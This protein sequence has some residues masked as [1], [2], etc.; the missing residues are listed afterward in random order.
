VVESTGDRR[1]QNSRISIRKLLNLN[2]LWFCVNA[3]Y[4][5]LIPVVIPTQILLFVNTGQVGSVDQAAFLSWLTAAASF[6]SLFM[7]PLV[8]H[9]SDL[10]PGR[11]GR[12]RP[13]I[14]IGGLLQTFSV[15]FLATAN[16]MVFFLLGLSILHVGNN[17]LTP[18]YQGLIPDQVSK[19]QRGAASGYVGAMTILGNVV[20]LALA[21]SLLGGITQQA[22]NAGMIRAGSRTYYSIT[23]AIMLIGLVFT[24]IGVR[25]KPYRSDRSKEQEYGFSQRFVQAW[26]QPW[27]NYNFTLVFFTRFSIMLGLAMFMTFIEYYFARVQ[28]IG[29]FVQFTAGV[30]VLA[31]GG[32]VFSGVISGLFSDRLKRR[33]PLVTVATICMSLASFAFVIFPN[34]LVMWLW[35]LG[36]LFGLGYGTYMSVDWAL[37]IDVLP[38]LEDAG[39]DLGLWGA[40]TTVPAIIAPL[41]GSLLI[42]I[43]AGSGQIEIGYR[44]V[45]I[46]AT[47]CLVTAAICI[48]L[49][50]EGRKA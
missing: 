5:A 39:K 24:L 28:H 40:S 44:L 6:I 34:T 30:A 37:S 4:A 17:I 47:L 32:G 2:V 46:A 29:N 48:L 10:T 42:H 43:A 22:Y 3:Q 15:I 13:Y 25:E 9:F 19:E 21:A 26:V 33:A 12:R 7:P 8:G 36:V 11:F 38:S 16:T 35:P 27:H 45:F 50:R 49:V 41:L 14:L 20:G 31:L 23:A 18:A 1:L